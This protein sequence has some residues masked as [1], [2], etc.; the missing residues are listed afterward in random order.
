[1]K[2]LY[3]TE[4]SMFKTVQSIAMCEYMKEEHG[5][6]VLDDPYPSGLSLAHLVFYMKSKHG[7]DRLIENG[8]NI[9]KGAINPSANSPSTTVKAPAP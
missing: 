2:G 4:L 5:D 6:A 7:L 3:L 8:A 1:M 9:N